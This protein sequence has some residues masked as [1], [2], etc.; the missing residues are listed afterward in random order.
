MF[1]F[2]ILLFL[3]SDLSFCIILYYDYFLKPITTYLCIVIFATLVLKFSSNSAQSCWLYCYKIMKYHWFLL[4]GCTN[5][6]KVK[7]ATVIPDVEVIKCKQNQWFVCSSDCPRAVH[8]KIVTFTI[9]SY[10]P[11]C[12]AKK[13]SA[14]FLIFCTD[15]R[16]K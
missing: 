2:V 9:H 8:V 7:L 10:F 6:N 16:S 13:T 15:R 14:H 12:F 4:V 3:I 5:L 11:F 1:L